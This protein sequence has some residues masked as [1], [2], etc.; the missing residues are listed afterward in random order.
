VTD[1]AIHFGEDCGDIYTWAWKSHWVLRDQWVFYGSLED[2]HI[3][4]NV[5][6]K[7]LCIAGAL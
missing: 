3:E 1:L 2:K 5:D 7:G 6:D 4:N